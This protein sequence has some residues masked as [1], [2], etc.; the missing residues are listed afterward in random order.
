MFRCLFE[1]MLGMPTQDRRASRRGELKMAESR[2]RIRR[3]SII[4]ALVAAAMVAGL[5][6][7][8]AAANHGP[9][10][11]PPVANDDSYTT[12]AGAPLTINAPGVLGNDNDPDR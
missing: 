8:P 5:G 9:L 3:R 12:P 6:V 2:L 7:G 1:E 4:A 10:N 11:Q